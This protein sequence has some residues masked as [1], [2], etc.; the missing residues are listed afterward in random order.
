MA[1]LGAPPCASRAGSID[2]QQ[3]LA[4]HV[5]ALA[6]LVRAAHFGKWQHR[7]D[8]RLQLAGSDQLRDL[9]ELR[10]TGLGDRKLGFYPELRRLL[11]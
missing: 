3:N 2:R 11:R 1:A 6:H 8:N 4:P 5:T 7:V 10:R 9:R